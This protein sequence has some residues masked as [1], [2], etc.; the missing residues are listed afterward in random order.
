MNPYV[1]LRRA[2]ALKK[3]TQVF[4]TFVGIALTEPLG[5]GQRSRNTQTISHWLDQLQGS[6]PQAVT[7]TLFKQMNG[8]RRQGNQR[9]FNSQTVLLQLLVESNLA[10]DLAAYSAFMCRETVRQAGS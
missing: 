6:P 3:L 10:L 1:H 5:A 7:H 9:R 2:Y 4:E 8:A